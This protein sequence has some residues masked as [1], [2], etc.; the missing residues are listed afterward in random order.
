LKLS[1]SQRYVDARHVVVRDLPGLKAI[2][3]SSS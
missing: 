2:L 3:D 1:C